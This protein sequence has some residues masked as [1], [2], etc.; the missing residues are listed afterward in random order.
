MQQWI[1][2]KVLHVLAC[3]YY[4]QFYRNNFFLRAK[5]LE[6]S[7]HVICLRFTLCVSCV[8]F[9][10]I[11]ILVTLLPVHILTFMICDFY[12]WYFGRIKKHSVI[13]AVNF[14]LFVL[15]ALFHV[16]H[17]SSPYLPNKIKL[18]QSILGYK[19]FTVLL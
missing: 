3:I 19:S 2:L 4:V 6:V 15:K 12:S 14:T 10:V 18:S 11:L 17:I 7:V 16:D 9:H 1:C 5:G 13:D 8:H